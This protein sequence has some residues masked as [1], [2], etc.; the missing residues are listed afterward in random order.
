MGGEY[1]P[2]VIQKI[3]LNGTYLIKFDDGDEIDNVK[4]SQIIPK[5]NEMQLAAGDSVTA[6]CDWG[7]YYNGVI[8]KVN[9]NGTYLIAFEDGDEVD[10]VR[11]TQIIP[12]SKVIKQETLS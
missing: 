9:E 7:E 8:Q 2:G 10:N 3:N 12:I 11:R 5:A 6:D 4:E 1:F